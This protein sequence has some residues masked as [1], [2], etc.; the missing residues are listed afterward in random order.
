[1]NERYD[2]HLALIYLIHQSKR[3]DQEFAER[4]IGDFRNDAAAFAERLQAVCPLKDALCEAPG[5]L[6]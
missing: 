3:I 4:G 1:M 5:A 6:R 2:P